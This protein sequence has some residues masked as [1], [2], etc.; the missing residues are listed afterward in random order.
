MGRK[1]GLRRPLGLFTPVPGRCRPRLAPPFFASPGTF[2]HVRIL[3]VAPAVHRVDLLVWRAHA[4]PHGCP[5]PD[6][7]PARPPSPRPEAHR[8]DRAGRGNACRADLLAGETLAASMTRRFARPP[9]EMPNGFLARARAR[10]L[11]LRCQRPGDRVP[12]RVVSVPESWR[13]PAVSRA[14]VEEPGA[15]MGAPDETR[16]RAVRG[17]RQRPRRC[18]LRLVRWDCTA[19]WRREAS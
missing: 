7:G 1:S 3:G 10:I 2:A 9:A 14:A 16:S 8:T 11:A 4:R 5:R 19:T 13:P 6:A 17:G 18:D 15:I 12:P